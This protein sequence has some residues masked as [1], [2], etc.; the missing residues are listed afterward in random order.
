MKCS[1]CDNTAAKDLPYCR[2]HHEQRQRSRAERE[3]WS[4]LGL[5]PAQEIAEY[6]DSLRASGLGWTTIASL[7]DVQERHLRGIRHQQYV[8]PGT[9]V[10]IMA[11]Q[12][13]AHDL[14]A[15]NAD[16]PAVGTKRRIRG[17]QRMGYTNVMLAEHS[18]LNIR[19]VDI[20]LSDQLTQVKASTARRIAEVF[21]AL[22]LVAPPD[23]YGSRR[24]RLRAER[25]GWLPPLAWD[26][27]TI[28][29][30]NAEPNLGTKSKSDDWYHDYEEMREWGLTLGQ[31]AERM[32]ILEDSLKQNLRRYQPGQ[33]S[34]T[35]AASGVNALKTGKLGPPV[36]LAVA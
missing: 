34:T 8:H 36:D 33:S 1:K 29:D 16:I 30:P 9:A 25:K 21:S 18:G 2:K 13:G 22:Q 20:T 23:T 6:I 15:D 12:P 27:D 31:I 5:L 32:G 10:R 26:E 4:Q 17:L 28:D 14:Q 7:S 11:V 19:T 35:P 3:G 24:A